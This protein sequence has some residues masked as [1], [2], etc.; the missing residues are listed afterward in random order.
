MKKEILVHVH[1]EESGEAVFQT[2]VVQNGE[3]IDYTLN[4]PKDQSLVG[5]IYLGLVTN[6]FPGTQSCFVDI[7]IRKNSI[8]YVKDMNQYPKAK[9]EKTIGS[10]AVNEA[11][12]TSPPIEGLVRTGQQIIVQISKDATGDKGPRVTTN[13]TLPGKYAVLIPNSENAFVS[14]RIKDPAEQARLKAI[15]NENLAE[16]FGL[17]ART[18]S[19]GVSKRLIRYDIATL[20]NKWTQITRKES[21]GKAPL[22]IHVEFDFYRSLINKCV[23]DDVSKLVIDDK[24]SYKELLNRSSATLIDIS[25]KIQ[26]YSES[27]PL[28]AFFGISQEIKSLSMRKVWLKCGAYIV[29]DKTEALTIIDVNSGKYNGG[30]SNP[31]DTIL[32][33]NTEAVVETA[34]QLRLRDVGGIIIIDIIRMQ[35]PAHN[36]SVVR[37]LETALSYDPQKTVVAGITRL[38]LLEMTRKKSGFSLGEKVFTNESEDENG[39]G[40]GIFG[41]KTRTIAGLDGLDAKHGRNT[42]VGDSADDEDIVSGADI[43]KN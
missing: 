25:Y 3:L 31:A 32:K 41:K 16:G 18:E 11:A 15:L 34:R 43:W 17:I 8:L 33:I 22:C 14:R 12:D 2:A 37:S 23:E 4:D 40:D 38:G 5:N 19:E 29:I 42:A 13:I 30:N 28:F 10:A 36:K 21:Y 35:P 6:I 24:P 7:G 26:H 1:K 20:L 9:P 27:Y 39:D